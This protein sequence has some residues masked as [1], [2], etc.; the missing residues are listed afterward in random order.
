LHLQPVGLM[1]G[2]ISGTFAA[3]GDRFEAIVAEYIIVV[4]GEEQ[5]LE[6]S[7]VAINDST[8]VPLRAMANML[9]KDVTYKADSRTIELNTPV[10]EVEAVPVVEKPAMDILNNK[11]EDVSIKI[12]VKII[13]I[14]TRKK[15]N[16]DDPLIAKLE[17]ELIVLQQQL[18]ELEAQKAQLERDWRHNNEY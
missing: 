10:L 18:S 7:P 12:H 5:V 1:A 14:E 9:G 16:I 13:A 4:D 2:S 8:Y 3:I 15:S 17:Q 6:V 11:I